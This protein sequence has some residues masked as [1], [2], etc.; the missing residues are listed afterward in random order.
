[1]VRSLNWQTFKA[2]LLL[3]R[4]ARA[5][6]QQ[7]SSYHAPLT[8]FSEEEQLMKDAA[9]NFARQKIQPLVK[10]MDEN[11]HMDA[12]VI[13]GLFKQGFM[14][15]EVNP[16]YGGTGAS[17]ISAILAIEELAKVDPSV[18][19]L[20]DVQNTL[21][22]EYFK[23]Y[24]SV[25][26][27]DKYLP[28]LVKKAVGSYC[29]S[30]PSCGSDAFALKTSAKKQG[31]YYI[32]NGQKAWITNAEHASVFIVMANCDFS[33]GYKGITSFVV[34]RDTPGLE[35]GKKENKLG[36]R[37]SSTC[38]VYLQDV[39]VHESQVIGQVGKGYKYAIE[40]LN[41][42]RIGIGAQMLGLAKG[43]LDTT[44]PY[45]HERKAFGKK[46][47]DFQA[48]MHIR[49]QLATE[50]E[51]ASLL[52]YN[53]ARLKDSGK[54]FVKEAAMAKYYASEVATKV[55]GRCVEMVGGAGF[56]KDFPV[57]KFYR[58]SKIGQIY[59]GTSFIQLNT[60]ADCMD[61]EFGVSKN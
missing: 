34:D 42:G 38:S 61:R 30:E 58:D 3:N 46:I 60:I 24:A 27:Q 55:A 18:S 21:V 41:V 22:N 17:F 25:A 4:T 36:I 43:A 2:A 13:Q 35:L 40:V 5:I 31:E 52:V 19:V 1:M 49:A 28:Q 37:A 12:S 54:P 32:L 10:E 50:I 26:L 39:K 44:I 9:A 56:T 16:K 57:E 51:A 7:Y 8:T 14:G 59:E 45:I 53:A 15:I 6:K 47:A 11:S 20:C 48:M 23:R 33:Q 29:L